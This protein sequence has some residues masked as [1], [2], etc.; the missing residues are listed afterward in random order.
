MLHSDLLAS[1]RRLKERAGEV[2]E[3]ARQKAE[4]E[5]LVAARRRQREAALEDDKAARRLAQARAEEEASALREAE[6][7]ANNGV[8]YHA[9]L[10][11]VPVPEAAAA[12]R[13][14]KRAADKLLLP[15]SAGASLMDQGAMRNGPMFFTV[16]TAAGRSTHA[17]LL[18]FT[19][20]EGFAALPRKVVR[21]LWGPNAGEG[22][23]AGEV[24][25]A[26]RRLPKGTHAVFQPRSALFQAAV[27]DEMRGVLEAALGAHSVLSVGDWIEARHG[28]QVY[29]LRVRAL[30]PESAVSV[31]DTD[32]E[33]EVHP[34]VE[35]EEKIAAE[36]AAAA[37]ALAAAARAVWEAARAAAAEAAA[38]REDAARR[39]EVRAG[40]AAALP[41]EPD[42]G[43]AE[44]AVAV[45]VRFPDGGA[46]RRR[47]ALAS[48]LQTLFDFVDARGGGGLLPGEYRL[49]TQYPRRVFDSAEGGGEAAAA[50]ASVGDAG[51]D[52]PRE[53][54]FLEPVQREG[55]GAGQV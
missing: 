17:A 42:E 45:L 40:K 13:G 19:A 31:I 47:L 20:A 43:G 30:Q 28:G 34:S 3:K 8:A 51:L 1:Q 4:K 46:H 6:L 23:C 35:T 15:P 33:A 5:A 7:E 55:G 9:R 37:A 22:A 39:E 36:E 52:G 27:G 32:L 12:G 48:P 24:Q 10:Q 44:P 16:T 41:P 11:A 2:A 38:E 14:I 29:D 18:E 53:V 49:V 54:L 50:G 25:V 21:S 26:Y